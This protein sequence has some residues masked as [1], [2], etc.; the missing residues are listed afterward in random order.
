MLNLQPTGGSRGQNQT[1]PNELIVGK[2]R[3]GSLSTGNADASEVG[4]TLERT[5]EGIFLSLTFSDES[6]EYAQWF[7]PNYFDIAAMA[8]EETPPRP[9]VPSALFF[10]DSYGWLQRDCRRP[11]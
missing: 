11:R 5:D 7:T 3:Y 2:P 9:S 6:P 1:M 8:A 10:Y 4:A